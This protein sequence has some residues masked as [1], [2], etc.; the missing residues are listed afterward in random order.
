MV[1]Y[2]V[3]DFFIYFVVDF[4]LLKQ[5]LSMTDLILIVI[6]VLKSKVWFS[7]WTL[8]L[9]CA[10]KI[11]IL[12][13][14]ILTRQGAMLTLGII[15]KTELLTLTGW[16]APYL[17]SVCQL[18]TVMTSTSFGKVISEL[19]GWAGFIIDFSICNIAIKIF[20]IYNLKGHFAVCV[21]T[22]VFDDN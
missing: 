7:H 5:N 4:F 2:L 10:L 21:Q 17:V 1:S 18:H 22:F 14:F 12:S 15:C 6:F 20:N 3:A 19:N 13:E 16:Q 11:Q 8:H 9:H